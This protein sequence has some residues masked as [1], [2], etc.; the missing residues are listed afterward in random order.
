MRGLV[1]VLALATVGCAYRYPMMARRQID[2]NACG[3]ALA[4]A[5]AMERAQYRAP[6]GNPYMDLQ[7]ANAL[8]PMAQWQAI[9]ICQGY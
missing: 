1:M 9:R 3:A 6:T 2:P 4:G 8:V 7:P 5:A